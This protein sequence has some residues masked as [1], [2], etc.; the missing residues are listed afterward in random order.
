MIVFFINIF[1]KR[2]HYYYFDLERN[3]VCEI[4]KN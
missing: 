4:P 3:R 2:Y 1:T